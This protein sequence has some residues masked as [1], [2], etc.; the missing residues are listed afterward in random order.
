MRLHGVASLKHPLILLDCKND[1]RHAFLLDH[2]GEAFDERLKAGI[3]TPPVKAAYRDV[4][5]RGNREPVQTPV[6]ALVQETVRWAK[7][8][9]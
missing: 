1:C 5:R 6:F 7:S 2:F 8:I 3:R 4:V 9:S